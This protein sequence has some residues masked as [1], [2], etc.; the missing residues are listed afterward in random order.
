MFHLKRGNTSPSLRA[1]LRDGAGA[2]VPLAGTTILF[3]MASQKGVPVITRRAAARDDAVDVGAVVVHWL[4]SD[5]NIVGV[6][7]AEFE[8]TYADGRIET[9]PNDG[10]LM[11]KVS[12]RL[13]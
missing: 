3:S 2:A 9:F 5:T 10:Y 8:V 6:F 13:A 12:G 1:I 7:N 11:V 4:G